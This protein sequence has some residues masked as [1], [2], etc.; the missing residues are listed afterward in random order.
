MALFFQSCL[1]V[2]EAYVFGHE[3]PNTNEMEINEVEL[4]I[5]VIWIFRV[6]SLNMVSLILDWKLIALLLMM[7]LQLLR[8]SMC[9][10]RFMPIIIPPYYSFQKKKIIPPYYQF[11]MN[12]I[13]W[14]VKGA[15]K[16]R[17]AS[18]IKDFKKAYAIDVFAILEPRISGPRALSVAQSLG[19]SCYYIVDASGFYRGVWLLWNENSISLQVVAHSS[20]SIT[21]LVTLR[22]RRWLLTVVYASLRI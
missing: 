13:A 19:F 5:R 22:N 1:W 11:M 15:G 8:Q 9:R 17:C 12:I 14:N 4:L 16:D 7:V 21:T 10:F 2:R 18:T 6:I 20:Q 3:P